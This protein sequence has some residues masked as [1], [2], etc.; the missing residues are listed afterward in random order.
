M[1][2]NKE[3]ARQGDRLEFTGENCDRYVVFPR[4]IERFTIDG[5]DFKEFLRLGR[6]TFDR[7]E[8]T[9][10]EPILL[11]IFPKTPFDGVF[12]PL[13]DYQDFV[14]LTVFLS[15]RKYSFDDIW[16]GGSGDW[17]LAQSATRKGDFFVYS[18]D[19]NRRPSYFSAPETEVYVM[20]HLHLPQDGTVTAA[21]AEK[22]ECLIFSDEY[23]YDISEAV[24]SDLKKLKNLKE[25]I[26]SRFVPDSVCRQEILRLAE[27]CPNVES[28]SVDDYFSA[29][30]R[31]LAAFPR[32]RHIFAESTATA[33][34]IERALRSIASP[35]ADQVQE[36]FC[37]YD[38]GETDY[39]RDDSLAEK[40]R[41]Q[42]SEA[43]VR[44]SCLQK[45]KLFTDAECEKYCAKLK[46]IYTETV[47]I[48]AA[49][50]G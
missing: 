44:L 5:M 10:R 40:L 4:Q 18:F 28:I 15:G 22:V 23:F 6:K 25:I 13:Y 27:C 37:W 7:Y 11:E 36:G 9:L 42:Y 8:L 2:K 21:D 45:E 46:S 19:R 32:L 34:K 50:N 35:L 30:P 39:A 48:L 20:Q 16:T 3:K 17:T 24:Y 41:E 31:E 12:L 47:A 1:R 26:F 38:D 14:D 33:Q 29:D 49:N 43:S